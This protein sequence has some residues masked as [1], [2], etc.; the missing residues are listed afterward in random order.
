MGEES[1]PGAVTS[2]FVWWMVF[3]AL[4]TE[5]PTCTRNLF[6][7]R[8][9]KTKTGLPKKFLILLWHWHGTKSESLIVPG[10]Q[11]YSLRFQKRTGLEIVNRLEPASREPERK[12]RVLRFALQGRTH[13][14]RTTTPPDTW[15]QHLRQRSSL[16]Y[17]V[18]Y[19][20]EKAVNQSQTIYEGDL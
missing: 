14:R 7:N 1:M 13:H 17:T 18:C 19:L 15:Q 9:N 3:P 5:M 2:M 8:N 4:P 20:R 11:I 16:F 6:C 12:L 10:C